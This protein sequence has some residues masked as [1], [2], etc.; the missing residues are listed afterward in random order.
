MKYLI[1]AGGI[2]AVGYVAWC[3]YPA[4][5]TKLGI[6]FSEKFTQIPNDVK[7]NF[8]KCGLRTLGDK[9]PA[10]QLFVPSGEVMIDHYWPAKVAPKSAGA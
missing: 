7:N 3:F 6:F 1:A 5:I 9:V 10:I 8:F 4:E 2:C